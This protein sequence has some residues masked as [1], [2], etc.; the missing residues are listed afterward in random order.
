MSPVLLDAFSCAGLG[1]DGYAQAGFEVVCVDNDQ[2]ALRHNP[3]ETIVGDAIRLL[4]DRG[5]IG[6]FDAVHASPP[7]QGYSATRQLAIAQGK[8]KGR[9]RNLVPVVRKLLERWG[10][11]WVI[12]N[13]ERSP[14][15]EWDSVCVCGS[16]FGLKVQR[17]RLFVSNAGLTGTACDHEVFDRDPITGKPRPWGV[18]YAK[19]DNIPGGGRTC[20]T[21][22]HALECMGV[23]AERRLPWKYLCEGLPPAYTLHIGSQIKATL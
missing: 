5:F 18:Y 3:H 12:E 4:N 2:A 14:L 23:P 22:E 7:C 17:H 1:A 6:Q 20:A 11:P 15:R 16:S 10:G 13:V 9:A 8:G 21:L 19:G